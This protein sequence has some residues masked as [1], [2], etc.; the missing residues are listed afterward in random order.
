M[1]TIGIT[2]EGEEGGDVVHERLPE[3]P[4]LREADIIFSSLNQN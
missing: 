3:T 2:W 1:T 4:E